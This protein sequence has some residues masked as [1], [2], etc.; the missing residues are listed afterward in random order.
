MQVQIISSYS[1]VYTQASSN[2]HLEEDK[3]YYFEILLQRMSYY[4]SNS[5]KLQIYQTKTSFTPQQTRE[6][7]NEVQV[8]GT[9]YS[10]FS[11]VQEFCLNN[12]NTQTPIQEVQ[13]IVVESPCISSGDCSAVQFSLLYNNEATGMGAPMT[14]QFLSSEQMS[15]VS[16]MTK[17]ADFG[18]HFKPQVSFKIFVQQTLFDCK[19][20]TLNDF[21]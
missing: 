21:N 16:A 5:L 14:V 15:R 11:E 1:W 2:I 19:C 6:A 4:S 18:Q 20:K 9:S 8:I 13:Q 10:F 12:W 7:Q 17:P 3:E